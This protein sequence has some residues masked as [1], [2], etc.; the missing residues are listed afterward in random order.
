MLFSIAF[1]ALCG[2]S[3]DDRYEYVPN[4]NILHEWTLV[5]ST[6]TVAGKTD[7]FQNRTIVWKFNKNKTVTIINNN[8]DEN[9]QSG[10]ASGTYPYI[11]ANNPNTAAC[12]KKITINTSSKFECIIIDDTNLDINEGGA[13]GINYHFEKVMPFTIN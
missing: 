3:K 12:D 11:I 8:T 2:C 9:L 4:E 6:G 10:L 1:I 5:K 13:D 7:E